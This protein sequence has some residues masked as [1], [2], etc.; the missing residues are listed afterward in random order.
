MKDR[1][2]HT[3]PCFSH[4]LKKVF[5]SR[6]AAG[7]LWDARQQPQVSPQAVFLALF[8]GFLFHPAACG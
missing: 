8:Y 2:T 6:P 5:L 4:Y 1:P 3:L 7:R